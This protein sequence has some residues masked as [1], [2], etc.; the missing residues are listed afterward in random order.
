M[1]EGLTLTACETC[2]NM[3]EGKVAFIYVASCGIV[4]GIL[5][6]PNKSN[7]PICIDCT[8]PVQTLALDSKC[9]SSTFFLTLK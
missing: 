5:K 4:V 7:P 2:E 9:I 8:S 3:K 6:M 1:Y